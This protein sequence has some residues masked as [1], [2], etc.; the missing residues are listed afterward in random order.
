[1]NILKTFVII[2]VIIITL[3]A[4]AIRPQTHKHFIL[5]PANFKLQSVTSMPEDLQSNILFKI[6]DVRNNTTKV[7]QTTQTEQ[8]TY[9]RQESKIIPSAFISTQTNN[10]RKN[11]ATTTEQNDS[12]E[13]L[14][15]VAN[16][17]DNNLNAWM[18]MEKRLHEESNRRTAKNN[19]STTSVSKNQSGNSN[20]SS[21][22][23]C[24]I[25]EN[26][27]DRK[28]RDE[29]IAWNVWRSNIQN[30]IMDDSNVDANYG[31]IFYFSFKVDKNRNISNIKI[32]S[33]DFGD[34]ASIGEVRK[35][36]LR[37]KG[38]PILDF[39]EGTNRSVVDF[40]GGF[41]MGSYSQY[42]TPGDYNDY[43]HIRTEY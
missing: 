32:I 30:K 24:P 33:T 26:L 29:L 43:E 35:A 7:T 40:T 16:M 20:V 8:N 9:Q 22:A 23:S 28:Y 10:T 18:E 2:S 14:Q 12:D 19:S 37:L 36:I 21:G 31:T 15:Q 17:L 27:K 4:M 6:G 25:C 1:M 39:P 5:E 42:A 11:T 34:S 13:T 3:C 41:L 38:K